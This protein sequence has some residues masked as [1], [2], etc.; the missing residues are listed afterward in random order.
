MRLLVQIS[1]I[2]RTGGARINNGGHTRSITD[3]I[4]VVIIKR[5]VRIAVRMIINPASCNIASLG[6][7][8]W[9]ADWDSQ[10][11]PHFRNDSI[12]D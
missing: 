6:I 5:R 9:T 12:S 8:S 7:Q 1:H 11:S 10:F 2:I 4:G 3:C